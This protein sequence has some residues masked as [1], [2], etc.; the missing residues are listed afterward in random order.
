M[1]PPVNVNAVT[2]TNT[3]HMS[4]P[5]NAVNRSQHFGFTKAA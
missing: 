5:V 4:P 1:S 2:Q 3:K